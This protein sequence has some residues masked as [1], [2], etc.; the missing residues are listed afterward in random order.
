MADAAHYLGVTYNVL[1]DW[2]ADRRIPHFRVGRRVMFRVASLDAWMKAREVPAD[3]ER[4][5]RPRS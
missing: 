5:Y 3:D 2:V 4:A 1:K